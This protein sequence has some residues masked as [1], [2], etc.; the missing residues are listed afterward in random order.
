MTSFDRFRGRIC[1][2]DLLG[3]NAQCHAFVHLLHLTYRITDRLL[4][5]SLSPRLAIAYAHLRAYV[6]PILIYAPTMTLFHS[7]LLVCDGL[8]TFSK[9]WQL[10]VL[11]AEDEGRSNIFC[12]FADHVQPY[13]HAINTMHPSID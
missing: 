6:R 13:I 8:S 11:C 9:E 10:S 2:D 5:Y 1:V 4:P 12:M 3:S 7:S